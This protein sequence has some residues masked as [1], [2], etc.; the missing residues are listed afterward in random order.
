MDLNE[1]YTLTTVIGGRQRYWLYAGTPGGPP[2]LSPWANQL[3]TADYQTFNTE[4]FILIHH[5]VDSF[6]AFSVSNTYY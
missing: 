6:F 2:C 5:P 3:P 4:N 1:D